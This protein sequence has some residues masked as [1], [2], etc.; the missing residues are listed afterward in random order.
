[1]DS[2][3]SLFLN[4][5]AAELEGMGKK[6]TPK[7]LVRRV[8]QR[9]QIQGLI[10]ASYTL[11]A[12][13]LGI[14]ASAGTIPMGIAPAYGACGLALV[15]CYMVLSETGYTERFQ[16]HYCVAQQ[17][18]VSMAIMLAFAYV[19][20][21]AGVVFLCSLFMVFNFTALRLTPRQTTTV[22]AAMAIGVAGLF[23][24]TDLPIS[25]PHDTPMERF[26]TAL[27]FGLFASSTRQ[28]LYRKSL[29]LKEACNRI[30]EMAELDELT[31]S[32][33]RR[34]VMR[35]LDDEMHRSRGAETP[36]AVA[37]I[38]LDWFKRINDEFGHATGDEVLRTF[39]ITVF[40]NIRG[41][42]KF[43]RY[44][45][46]EFLLMLP[47]MSGDGAA[48]VL[49]RLRAIVA[50]LDWSAISPGMQVTISAGVT[51]IQPNET[52]ETL[53]ARADRAL[54]SAKAQ[55]RNRIAIA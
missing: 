14:Y 49:D 26:A 42:D 34:C 6:P 22:W 10:A 33:N 40:A 25:M 28:S 13:I 46:E 54:Y 38:D 53:L 21:E 12:L 29:Q 30:E 18:M 39:A 4:P 43:G 17:A 9:R 44:G 50:D 35:L 24:L 1:M 2:A 41:V 11:D 27:V 37:L 16:D 20:P 8:E 45:G 19:A 5:I 7:A 23:L 36:C 3:A 32:F 47:D 52:S 55:G 51:D 48:R 15:A 31:G